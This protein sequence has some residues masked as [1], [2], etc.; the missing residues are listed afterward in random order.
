MKKL[1]LF[2]VLILGFIN[3]NKA[4]FAASTEIHYY[5]PADG[6]DNSVLLVIFNDNKCFI[7]SAHIY[8]NRESYN[9]N[10][11]EKRLLEGERGDFTWP[12]YYYPSY[13]TLKYFT[14]RTGDSPE[15]RNYSF[16]KDKNTFINWVESKYGSYKFYYMRVSRNDILN[17]GKP[18]LDFLE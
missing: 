1:I 6:K 10:V 7:K 16:S 11:T 18:N 3:E 12:Y 4:Q 13:S 9:K 17:L 15:D 8:P 2:I 5:I 14:Y